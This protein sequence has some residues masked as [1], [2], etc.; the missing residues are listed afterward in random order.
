MKKKSIFILGLLATLSLGGCQT[1]K[2][3]EE[4]VDLSKA[5]IKKTNENNDLMKFLHDNTPLEPTKVFDNLYCIGTRSV[6]A[7]VLQTEEG[8]I[9]ID[10]MWDNRDAK[11]IEDDMEKLGLNPKDIKYILISHGHGDHYGGAKYLRD[12]YNAKVLITKTDYDVMHSL[13]LGPNGPRSP[14]ADIDDFMK[15]KD[16]IKLGNT[17]VTILETPGHTEGC[18][19]FIFPVLNEGKEYTA[20]L[21]GGTGIPNDKNLQQKYKNS[22]E[23][24]SQIARERGAEVELTA[25][26]FIENGYANLEKVANLKDGEK[27]PFIIGKDGIEQY[28]KSLQVDIDK[29]LNNN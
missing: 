18:A 29:K 16:I 21:W 5:E 24:F 13:N 22:V 14:K 26:L 1:I 27:N 25:H 28:L 7:W 6:V 12:K 10:S 9:L 8:I 15:D 23:Y 17:E 4:K 3:T 2:A 19:S 11:L 20:I